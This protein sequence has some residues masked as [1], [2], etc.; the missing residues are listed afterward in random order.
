MPVSMKEECAE[1]VEA[2]VDPKGRYQS[3]SPRGKNILK[4]L[5]YRFFFIRY[6]FLDKKHDQSSC[7]NRA[8][9][10]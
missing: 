4:F 2:E 1:E 5:Q 8:R 9:D 10:K 6:F 3:G 7:L